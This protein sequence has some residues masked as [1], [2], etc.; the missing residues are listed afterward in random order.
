MDLERRIH[1]DGQER[2][3][4]FQVEGQE[5]EDPFQI[6][7]LDLELGENGEGFDPNPAPFSDSSEDG[8]DL[9]SGWNLR[10]LI[11]SLPAKLIVPYMVLSLL[12]AMVGMFVVTRLVTSSIRERFANQLLEASRVAADATVRREQEHLEQLRLMAFTEGVAEALAREEGETIDNLLFPLVLN[13]DLDLLAATDPTGEELISLV[14]DPQSGSY[15]RSEGGD[16]ADISEIMLAVQAEPDRLGD[17]F[18]GLVETAHGPYLITTAPVRNEQERVVGVL[19]IG[20]RLQ[21][22]IQELKEQAL[23]DLILLE[24]SGSLMSTTLAE[25]EH[26]YGE[27]ELSANEV[28][29][30][31]PALSKELSLYQRTYQ[32]YFA[33]LVVRQREVGVLAVVLPS[34][35][36]VSTE[37]VSRN[38]ISLIFTLGTFSIIG[39]GYLL[40]KS[41]A[42]PLIRLR[43]V[44]LAVASGDLD[45]RTGLESRGEVGQLAAVFDLMT[46]RLRRRTAQA[47]RLYEETVQRNKEL[48][49]ANTRL[50]MAQQQLIQSEKLAA[51]GQL[52]AGIV[53]D[54]KNPLAVI[55]GL[56]EEL[57]EEIGEQPGV[58]EHLRLIRKSAFRASNIVSDLLKFARQSDPELMRQD[59]CSTVKSSLRLTDYLARKGNVKIKTEFDAPEVMANYDAT[60]I[61]QVLINLIQNAIQAMPDGGRLNVHVRSNGEWAEVDV[62]DSGTGIPEDTLGRIFDPFFTTK[63]EGEG[64]GLGLSVSYGIVK[65]HKGDIDVKSKVGEGT[66]FTI[67]LPK[68]P[69]ATDGS[70]RGHGATVAERG[71]KQR[72]R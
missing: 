39:V 62:E 26:G 35:F 7:D 9:S 63:P 57:E 34:N 2:E 50:Q 43:D 15:S 55:A 29:D 56:A 4:P 70:R 40:A 23:A 30:L 52:T 71:E 12:T 5:V 65:Q 66:K 67:K 28:A 18:A 69:P 59:I 3:H 13:G 61:E 45:Q 16:L 21:R 36:I 58:D 51:V 20:T 53:H 48:A 10:D 24:P 11:H 33:P 64:T 46:Y 54:V 27:L 72:T 47:A 38:T 19:I 41:I 22:M 31:E 32:T 60:Q 49:Q 1:G 42:G 6:D 17:K 44:A 14:R 25:P 68:D 8:I 37:A